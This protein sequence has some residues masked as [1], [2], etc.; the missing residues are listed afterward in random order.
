MAINIVVY[1]I[2]YVIKIKFIIDIDRNLFILTPLVV[3]IL[4]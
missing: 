4:Y 1:W 2:V 3:V